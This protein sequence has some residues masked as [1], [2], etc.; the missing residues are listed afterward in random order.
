MRISDWSSDVCSSDLF[1]QRA[2]KGVP[3]DS[4]M[5]ALTATI[6]DEYAARAR[7]LETGIV[8][9]QQKLY[10]ISGGA[11]SPESQ[12]PTGAAESATFLTLFA[13]R[14]DPGHNDNL[15]APEA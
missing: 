12:T 3:L 5:L 11:S 15:P 1:H 14:T 10:A 8:P 13:P 9:P 6:I 7:Q 2:V 4:D